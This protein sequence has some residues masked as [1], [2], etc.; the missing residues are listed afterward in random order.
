MYLF[1]GGPI[2]AMVYKAINTLDSMVGYTTPKYIDL[3]F[4]SAKVDD[5]ANY[6]PARL[7]LIF[8]ICASYIMKLDY[9]NCARIGFRD[10]RKHKSP[11]S[12]YP[13]AAAA[14]VLG[15][16]LGGSHV[17]HGVEIY[18]P[19]IGDDIRNVESSDILKTNKI[20]YLSVIISFFIFGLLKTMIIMINCFI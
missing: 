6:I 19:Y 9:K 4:I 20:L 11:N 7:T 10:C 3:G 1:I 8:M 15:I 5:F 18:K 12:G 14:G 17:Y 13:E 2:L 16:Q